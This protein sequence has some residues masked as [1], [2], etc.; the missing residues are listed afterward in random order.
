MKT[1]LNITRK[2]FIKILGFLILIPFAGIW[3]NMVKRQK[4]STVPREVI[5][6]DE[7]IEGVSIIENILVYKSGD[8]LK[9]YSAKCTHLGCRIEK[10]DQGEFVC[11]CHGSRYSVFDGQVTKG[12]SL[13]PLQL[14][15]Y[16]R[17]ELNNQIIVYLS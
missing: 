8:K 4:L 2:K 5:I 11:P 9:I 6:P 7:L 13:K 12:P 3:D 1:N 10:E 14:L 17:D 16:E 15:D